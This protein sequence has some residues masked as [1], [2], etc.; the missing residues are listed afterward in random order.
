M[1]A[2][3]VSIL[4][5]VAASAAFT[6]AVD[7]LSGAQGFITT[8]GQRQTLPRS[9]RDIATYRSFPSEAAAPEQGATFTSAGL[10]TM[11]ATVGLAF[12]L[13]TTPVYAA[14]AKKSG[15]LPNLFNFA[16]PEAAK[17]APA[18][19][20]PIE[21]SFEKLSGTRTARK[22][23]RESQRKAEKEVEKTASSASSTSSGF[24]LPSFPSPFNF[25]APE[26]ANFTPTVQQMI[27]NDVALGVVFFVVP[28]L[29][30]VFYILGSVNA[31]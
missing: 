6:V 2:S 23:K 30:V 13:L 22:A 7:N 9:Q 4:A 29:Y 19:V 18:E 1:S 15:F 17:P 24:A 12:S 5:V 8:S 27:N 26:A 21:E 25:G 3:K 31:I 11:A 28:A 14:E 10:M 16:A 20:R